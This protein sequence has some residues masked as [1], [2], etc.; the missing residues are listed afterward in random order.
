MSEALER[1]QQELSFLKEKYLGVGVKVR[2]LV[3]CTHFHG[4]MCGQLESVLNAE[5]EETMR[6]L[7]EAE[8]RRLKMKKL[9]VEERTA[10]KRDVRAYREVGLQRWEEEQHG[11]G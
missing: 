1:S 3:A 7:E 11:V 2:P 6:T 4:L 5:D 9:L 10:R 8:Q